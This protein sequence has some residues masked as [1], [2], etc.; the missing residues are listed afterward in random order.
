MRAIPIQFNAASVCANKKLPF[1]PSFS[2]REGS[3]GRGTLFA[4]NNDKWAN[5]L[6]SE[7]TNARIKKSSIGVFSESWEAR[8]ISALVLQIK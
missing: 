5:T 4:E 8:N 3:S 1:E 6:I 7:C 2:L